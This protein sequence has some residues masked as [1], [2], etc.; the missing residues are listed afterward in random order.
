MAN[1]R[2]PLKSMQ[3]GKGKRPEISNR[4][5]NPNPSEGSEGDMQ[6][7][8]TNLGARIFAKIGGN[9]LSSI[10][11]GSDIDSQDV[12]I[13]KVWQKSIQAPDD[14]M[15]SSDN[16][17]KIYLPDFINSKN[18]LHAHMRVIF[19]SAAGKQSAL[20]S[21]YTP[22]R[23]PQVEAELV[24]YAENNFIGINEFNLAQ[25]NYTATDGTG[26]IFD[27]TGDGDWGVI[28]ITVLFK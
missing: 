14:P 13:P 25:G 26:Y 18:F 2:N 8:Q 22:T 23:A 16:T 7:R 20:Q 19:N 12:C 28:V 4:Q 24:Y 27:D 3:W 1:G 11:F 17:L 10:L 9:W 21:F 5:G 6:V 15:T